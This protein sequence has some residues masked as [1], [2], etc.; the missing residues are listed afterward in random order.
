MGRSQEI[1][2]LRKISERGKE[3][4][5]SEEKQAGEGETEVRHKGVEKMNKIYDEYIILMYH[6][7]QR[8]FKMNVMFWVW[9][10]LHVFYVH[11]IIVHSVMMSMVCG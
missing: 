3:S 4:K 8:G 11:M 7:V 5:N 6:C 9:V 2:E 1:K 10:H